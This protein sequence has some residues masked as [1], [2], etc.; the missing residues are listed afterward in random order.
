[1]ELL[2]QESKE[3]QLRF[4]DKLV[5]ISIEDTMFIVN[6]N[7]FEILL[8]YDKLINEYSV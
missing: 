1:M 2:L 8:K 6:G 7:D 3:P 4:G 5:S